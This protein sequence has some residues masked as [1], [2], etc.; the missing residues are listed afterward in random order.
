MK[1][2][3]DLIR[4]RHKRTKKLKCWEPDVY[5]FYD[6]VHVVWKKV[7]KER[8]DGEKLV[9][10]IRLVVDSVDKVKFF[11]G[12]DYVFG[13]FYGKPLKKSAIILY[14]RDILAA[15]L[16]Q[17]DLVKEHLYFILNHEIEHYYGLKHE[18]PKKIKR[19]YL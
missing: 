11:Q 5:E 12:Q 16:W 10:K 9:A 7:L 15:N 17:K 6:I 2:E 8:K 4:K 3:K 14:Q 18:L 19:E 1:D 13:R